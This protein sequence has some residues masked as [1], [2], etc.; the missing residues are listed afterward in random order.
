[1]HSVYFQLNFI[2]NS[3]GVC[4]TLS[5]GHL[6]H[7]T[8]CVD[9][10]FYVSTFI[11]S[12][13]LWWKW[14]GVSTTIFSNGDKKEAI[15]L[16]THPKWNSHWTKER[17]GEK[18]GVNRV[19]CSSQVKYCLMHDV[20]MWWI[21]HFIVFLSGP[22]WKVKIC[23]TMAFHKRYIMAKCMERDCYKGYQNQCEF[24]FSMLLNFGYLLSWAI[25]LW[26]G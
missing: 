5:I 20:L 1:M 16:H 18:A 7:A 14:Y 15:G 22:L 24:W 6:I 17:A 8:H 26:F 11:V 13:S 10:Y 3:S 23:H 12:S 9:Y 25:L 19:K 4:G 2:D 21:I